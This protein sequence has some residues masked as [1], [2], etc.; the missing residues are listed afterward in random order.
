MQ[1]DHSWLI[2]EFGGTSAVAKMFDIEPASV[3]YWRAKGIP[4]ARLMY[5]KA[6]YPDKFASDGSVVRNDVCKKP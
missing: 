5:L 4:K 3:S 1:T 6:V 2:D